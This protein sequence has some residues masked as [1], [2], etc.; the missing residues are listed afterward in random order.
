MITQIITELL[1]VI[2]TLVVVVVIS[3]IIYRIFSI[4]LFGNFRFDD[5]EDEDAS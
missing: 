1:N 5:Y 4:N 3:Y 2:T